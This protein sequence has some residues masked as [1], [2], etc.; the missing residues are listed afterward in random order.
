MNKD[1][2][3]NNK[4]FIL[5]QD[6]IDMINKIGKQD[7]IDLINNHKTNINLEINLD[8]MLVEFKV[9]QLI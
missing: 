3:N 6:Q 4:L 9:I 8:Q 5:I 2:S 7:K 1:N